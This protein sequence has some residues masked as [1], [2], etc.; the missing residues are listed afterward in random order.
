MYYCCEEFLDA[1]DVYSSPM[2]EEIPKRKPVK[3]FELVNLALMK[4]VK[5]NRLEETLKGPKKKINKHRILKIKIGY[6]KVEEELEKFSTCV[7][8][9]LKRGTQKVLNS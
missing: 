7:I 1:N 6:S 9:K 4:V 3:S 5:N 8:Y 2:K